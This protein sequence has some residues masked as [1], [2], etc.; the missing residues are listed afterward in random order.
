MGNNGSRSAEIKRQEAHVHNQLKTDPRASYLKKQGYSD[1]KLLCKFR[2]EYNN[3]SW[4]NGKQKDS[5]ILQSKIEEAERKT[6]Y[7]PR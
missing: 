7:K 1:A 5:Y 3:P 4:R 2:Q 6:H